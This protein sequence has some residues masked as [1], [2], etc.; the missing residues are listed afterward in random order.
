MPLV[1]KYDFDLDGR[2][3]GGLRLFLKRYPKT[4]KII[5]V[6]KDK[7]AEEKRGKTIIEIVPLWKYLLTK[8]ES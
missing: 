1:V 3:F 2:K 5:I 7:E 6:S 8:L 4:K